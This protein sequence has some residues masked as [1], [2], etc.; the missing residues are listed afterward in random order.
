[1]QYFR[2]RNLMLSSILGTCIIIS[3]GNSQN[4]DDDIFFVKN[5]YEKALT[6]QLSYKWLTYL[7]ETIGGRIAG[8]P[9]SMAA[10]EFTAQVLDTIGTDT[11]W[12]QACMVNYWYRGA[13]EEIA[14]INHSLVGTRA[15]NCL[16][17]GGSGATPKGGLSGTVIEVQ[18][19]EEARKL[20]SALKGKIVYYSR[21]FENKHLRTFYGYGGAVDQRVFGANIASK[22]GAKACVIRSMTGRM[23]NVP[24]TGSTIFEEGV[25]PI[26]AVAISTNDAVLLSNCMKAGE[27]QLFIKTNC[28]W[29]GQK[30][31]YSVIGEI[32]G[33]ER[34]E[35]IILVGGHLDSWDVGGGAHDDGAGCVHSM[36]VLHLLKAMNYKPKRTIRCVL[37][38][39]EENGLAGATTYSRISNEKKEFHL[40]A[41]E[42]DAGGFTPLG[43]GFDADSSVLLKYTQN[44]SK[45]EEVLG[46]YN[47]KFDKGGS[48]A[49]V[50]QLKSQK[51]LLL[52]LSPDSQRYFDY[53]H[54]EQDRIQAVH[55]RELALGSAA[56]ASLVYLID[57]YGLGN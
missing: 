56:M 17:L 44:L 28:E 12:R 35:E 19:L 49:D 51:G 47:I 14:I 26:P 10:I 5:I 41:I 11:V 38:Q 15:L 3:K 37:F 53:H 20:G 23:D 13:R 34:P 39:N 57:K 29:R 46:P 2:F 7:S 48:G 52:G 45:W 50:G 40:A 25:T 54:T 31:S 6:E 18:S 24:H 27:T 21:P 32:R 8:S 42:S 55:P 9:Q 1:M 4:S 30:Q 36:E 43:F 22:F 16:A 33:S